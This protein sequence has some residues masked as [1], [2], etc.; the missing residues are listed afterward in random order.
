MH[1]CCAPCLIGVY[2]EL[3]AQADHITCV[4]YNPNIAPEDEY[5]RRRDTFVEYVQSR[6]ID[7][8]EIDPHDDWT[9]EFGQFL[10]LSSD[11]DDTTRLP[12][13]S[14]RC[15]ACYRL[16][17]ARVGQWAIHNGCDGLATTLTVSPWQNIDAIH[18]AGAEVELW[19]PEVKFVAS[20]FRDNYRM[21]QNKATAQG[22]YRQNYCGCL[23]S[24]VEAQEQR[25]ARKL[26]RAADKAARKN[27]AHDHS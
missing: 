21:A 17:L 23:S 16:R 11:E 24:A 10:E 22:L 4:F 6:N 13:C 27:A 25:D 19:C 20:D 8:V 2:D 9:E 3:A 15:R 12:E 18:Y 5:T 26:Q 1:T 14:V 7:Y